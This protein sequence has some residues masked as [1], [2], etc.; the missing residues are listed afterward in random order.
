MK[1]LLNLLQFDAR[2]WEKMMFPGCSEMKL[3][4]ENSWTKFSP[5]KLKVTGKSGENEQ[6][7]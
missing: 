5:E 4:P 7:K 1:V 2:G 6:A 3:A